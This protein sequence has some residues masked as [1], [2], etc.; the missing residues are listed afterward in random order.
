MWKP[1][2]WARSSNQSAIA[3]A[4][5][6]AVELGGRRLERAEVELFLTEQGK[7]GAGAGRRVRRPA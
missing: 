1:W 5:D 2:G 3:N 7:V 4:R 6:G